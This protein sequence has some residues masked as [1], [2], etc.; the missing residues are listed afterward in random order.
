MRWAHARAMHVS[1]LGCVYR[2]YNYHPR[3]RICQLRK[4]RKREA[5]MQIIEPLIVLS[6]VCR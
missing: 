5:N 3:A 2:I 4:A 1:Q 6:A